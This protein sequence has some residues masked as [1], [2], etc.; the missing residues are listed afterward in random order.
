MFQTDAQRAHPRQREVD[1]ANAQAPLFSH[2]CAARPALDDAP[3]GDGAV[4]RPRGCLPIGGK[5][6]ANRFLGRHRLSPRTIACYEANLRYFREWLR[7]EGLEDDLRALILANAR[8]YGHH[9]AE[10]PARLATFVAGGA[11]RGVQAFTTGSRPISPF[12]ASGYLRTLKV[13]TRW[14]ADEAQ[15][16]TSRDV[17]A[18]LRLTATRR[19]TR[20]VSLAMVHHPFIATSPVLLASPS[21]GRFSQPGP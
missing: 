17:L 16:Y 8:R 11:R 3:L 21:P 5:R 10:R 13:F 2:G 19:P 6:G 14:L 18:G 4:I 1:E 12:S 20:L 7:E 15:G 9:L